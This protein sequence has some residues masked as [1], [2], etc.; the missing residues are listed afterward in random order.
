MHNYVN[1]LR[2]LLTACPISECFGDTRLFYPGSLQVVSKMRGQIS[3][4]SS[5]YKK[6]SQTVQTNTCPEMSVFFIVI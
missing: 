2:Q 5:L 3:R 4:V 1:E 6:T